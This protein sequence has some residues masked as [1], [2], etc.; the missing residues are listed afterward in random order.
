MNEGEGRQ[1][2]VFGAWL[3]AQGDRPNDIGA[4]ARAARQDPLFP[5]YGD[6]DA[7]RD[8]VVATMADSDWWATC[9]AAHREWKDAG[10]P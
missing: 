5:R 1:P 4:L 10:C 6:Y 7:V 3:L 2:T 9:D 8:R